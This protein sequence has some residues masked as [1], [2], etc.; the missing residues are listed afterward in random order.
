[1]DGTGGKSF[2]VGELFDRVG[3]GSIG[4]IVQTTLTGTANASLTGLTISAGDFGITG[5]AI[6]LAST[7]IFAAGGPNF[8]V[9]YDG[10]NFAKL[11]NLKNA[12]WSEIYDGIKLGVDVLSGPRA[13]P[14]S[15]RTQ[16]FR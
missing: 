6:A 14:A 1:M 12:S 10:F 3:D 7:N 4:S 16:K 11:G 15:S 9:T 13:S 8:A 2:S 5:T